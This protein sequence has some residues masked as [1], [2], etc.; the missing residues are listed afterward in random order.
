MKEFLLLLATLTLC[1]SLNDAE[2]E[3][4]K[5]LVDQGKIFA[6]PIRI[7]FSLLLEIF[8]RFCLSV[9]DLYS[10]VSDFINF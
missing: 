2:I 10:L 1:W 9:E 4:I 7:I 5:K 3:R 8:D 6:S